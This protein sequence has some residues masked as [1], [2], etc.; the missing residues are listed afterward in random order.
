MQRYDIRKVANAIIL[1]IDS[2]VKHLG[3]T[4][5]MKL[6]FFADKEHLKCYGRPI[7]FDTYFKKE[8]GPVPSNTYTVIS[9]VNDAE[10]EDYKEEVKELLNWLEI[11]EKDIGFEKPMTVFRK[12]RDFIPDLFSRSEIKVLNEVFA[13]FKDTKANEISHLS[14]ELPEYREALMHSVIP[15]EAMAEDMAEYVRFWEEERE[16]FEKAV[17]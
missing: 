13:R 17:R 3:K 9:S 4:K 5:L 15:Y 1:A 10:K 16:A 7:F 12:K 2:G 6:L 14:H 8:R 11:E